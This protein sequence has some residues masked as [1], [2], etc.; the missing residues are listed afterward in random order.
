[1]LLS[2][3]PCLASLVSTPPF[4]SKSFCLFGFFVKDFIFVLRVSIACV[5]VSADDCRG[6]K[7]RSDLPELQLQA[8]VR[9]LLETSLTFSV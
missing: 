1:M 3:C 6:R 8:V 4:L 9:H 7:R 5:H 2:A